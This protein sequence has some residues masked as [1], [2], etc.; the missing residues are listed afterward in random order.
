M[1]AESTSLTTHTRPE[2]G[3]PDRGPALRPPDQVPRARLLGDRARPHRAAGGQADGRREERRLRL[4]ARERGV[5]AG[6]QPAVQVHRQEPQPGRCRLCQ[7]IRAHPRRPAQGRRRRQAFRRLAGRPRQGGRPDPL[8]RS[9]GDADDRRVQPRLQRQHRGVHQQPARHGRPRRS[10]AHRAHRRARRQR[11]RRSEDLQGHRH[12]PALR[13]PGGDHRPTADH[14]PQPDA[15][16]DADHLRR[17]VAHRRPGGDL[18]ADPAR[19]GGER[20]ERRHPGR[21]G[22]GREH[23]LRAAARRALPRGVA[24]APG[25]A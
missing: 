8:Q 16:A 11:R 13:D 18:P 20:P 5:N 10:R 14:L 2:Q 24:Q 19:A 4:P 17:G 7:A 15:L 21:A 3:K 1:T 9:Q 12:H 6:A 25:P 22:T 23:R